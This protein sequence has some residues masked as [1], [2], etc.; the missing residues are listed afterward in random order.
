MI[1]LEVAE[2]TISR[3]RQQSQNIWLIG[4]SI[5]AL[6]Q[7][8][9]PTNGYILKLFF[10]LKNCEFKTE[11][12]IKSNSFV[13]DAVC[14][15]VLEVWYKNSIETQRKDKIKEKITKLHD[16]YR[17]VQKR[18]GQKSNETKQNN[19]VA[20]LENYFFIAHI[21]AEETIWK[22]RLRNDKQKSEDIKFLIAIKGNKRV[23]LG[24]PD[25][26]YAKK[27]KMKDENMETGV[28]VMPQMNQNVKVSS[29][30]GKN[31]RLLFDLL[32]V[33]TKWLSLY[34]DEWSKNYEFNYIS[35][36]LKDLKVVNDLVERSVKLVTDFNQILTWDKNHKQ[37]LFKVVEQHRRNIPKFD[38]AS[39]L[40]K[41]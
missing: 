20:M 24:T 16:E 7:T 2:S 26:Q 31:S 40:M 4:N 11:K 22:D 33:N 1:A 29:L 37:C 38:K 28:A 32:K 10:H 25:N 19:F 9:I 14:E 39:M 41:K 13:A 12:S 18:K 21:N 8:I 15:A 5:D 36:I 30:I 23:K 6:S 27:L 35:G 34:P 17:N 3:R